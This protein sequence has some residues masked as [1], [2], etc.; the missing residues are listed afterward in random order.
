MST[1]EPVEPQYLLARQ[2]QIDALAIEQNWDISIIQRHHLNSKKLLWPTS[3][4]R[5]ATLK[6]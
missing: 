4:D 5:H 6:I 1:T 3:M 2:I